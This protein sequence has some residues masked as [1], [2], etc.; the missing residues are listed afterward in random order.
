ML[1]TNLELHKVCKLVSA[2]NLQVI[3]ILHTSWFMKMQVISSSS[4]KIFKYMF[5]ADDVCWSAG[6]GAADLIM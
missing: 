5:I 6:D 4:K 1:C 3:S 2:Q